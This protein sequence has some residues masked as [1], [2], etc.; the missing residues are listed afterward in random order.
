MYVYSCLCVC[1]RLS[2]GAQF[3]QELALADPLGERL[4]LRGGDVPAAHRARVR[5]RLLRNNGQTRGRTGRSHRKSP[6]IARTHT[7]MCV[8]DTPTRSERRLYPEADAA[9]RG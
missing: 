5:P 6:R 3:V 7:R 4:H 2:G 8:I 1:V 9:Q